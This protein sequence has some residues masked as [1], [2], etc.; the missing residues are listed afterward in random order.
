M[1]H[2]HSI[3]VLLR[4]IKTKLRDDQSDQFTFHSGSIKGIDPRISPIMSLKF[5]FHSGSIKGRRGGQFNLIRGRFTFH[6]GSIKGIP[7]I[8]GY[9]VPLIIYIPFWFY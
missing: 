2:L 9:T 5:T 7:E 1:V 4:V 3:L 8:A 6:S